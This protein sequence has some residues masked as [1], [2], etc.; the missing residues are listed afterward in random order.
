MV[1]VACADKDED[2]K[3]T[4]VADTE[5]KGLVEL[6]PLEAARKVFNGSRFQAGV[7]QASPYLARC[8][9]GFDDMAADLPH[10][11]HELYAPLAAHAQVNPQEPQA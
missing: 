8:F 6:P 1:G 10:W 7:L 3:T 11:A 5:E 2:D 9:S 4:S